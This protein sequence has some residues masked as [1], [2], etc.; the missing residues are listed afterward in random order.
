MNTPRVNCNCWSAKLP[1]GEQ[2]FP[3]PWIVQSRLQDGCSSLNETRARVRFSDKRRTDVDRLSLSQK[4]CSCHARCALFLNGSD[5]WDCGLDYSA[6][7]S[8][9]QPAQQ[10]MLCQ[11]HTVWIL[12]PK[13]GVRKLKQFVTTIC[14][15]ISRT[16]VYSVQRTDTR[17]NMN[18]DSANCR[19]GC[20]RYG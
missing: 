19:G 20:V 12:A 8:D 7:E 16:G 14:V 4:A 1:P 17:N 13:T 15:R 10:P 11:Q 6:S 2:R 9:S 3:W 18:D 5:L